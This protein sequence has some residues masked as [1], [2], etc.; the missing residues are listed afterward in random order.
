MPST[1][2]SSATTPSYTG[3]AGTRDTGR[4]T[5]SYTGRTATTDLGRAA[6][7]DLGGSSRYEGRGSLSSGLTRES[8]GG[9]TRGSS[10]GFTR[11]SSGGYTGTTRSS[12][13]TVPSALDDS[14]R[15][16]GSIDL[17]PA[18]SSR[19]TRPT[20]SS[21]PRLYGSGDRTPVSSR[22]LALTERL[23]AAESSAKVRTET[24]PGRELSTGRLVDRYTPSASD[25][26]RTRTRTTGAP[27]AGRPVAGRPGAARRAAA[28]TL[29]S[30]T[31]PERGRP[32]RSTSP[33]AR[34]RLRERKEGGGMT[35]AER[36]DKWKKQQRRYYQKKAETPGFG[37]HMSSVST[38]VAE[39][40]DLALRAALGANP[41]TGPM[42]GYGG[43]H[44]R[45]GD[46]R[47]YRYTRQG[48][49][50][51]YWNNEGWRWWLGWGWGWGYCWDWCW[52]WS[53]SWW[54]RHSC[55]GWSTWYWPTYVYCSPA[56][57]YETIEVPVYI[58]PE[59]KVVVADPAPVQGPAPQDSGMAHRA[60]SEYMA[61][62]DRAFVEGRYGDAVH[63]YA[64][65][66]EFSPEDG[67]LYLVLSD[68]LF[69][70]GD[71]HYC[72]FAIRRALELNP[73]LA[74][75]AVDKRTFYGD[76]TDFDLQLELLEVYL[77]DHFLDGDARLVLAANYLFGDQPQ[78]CVD[79][80]DSPFSE[81][82]RNGETG[83]LL[84]AAAVGKLAGAGK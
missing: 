71:Y 36:Q 39:A 17:S 68:A 66:I 4:T 26:G 77:A 60:A 10:G 59:E 2:G 84:L 50:D 58:E 34:E 29:R 27:A 73:E 82:V 44:G 30:R 32:E 13:S 69:A 49:W 41:I 56:V 78:R 19:P 81:E 25:R 28:E 55:G 53:C 79:L 63:Y 48:C 20:T 61:L 21:V 42:C 23:R 24:A 62:G 43:N 15:R 57:I 70:T 35:P 47:W 5:P 22:R 12:R 72:A 67:V 9:Y 80:F 75:L 64:K 83:S 14:S 37:S 1:G 18:V 7:T 51:W 38:A 40:N 76:P 33:S 45:H 54:H 3:R 16:G 31:T 46:D 11:D 74:S 52:G 8:S 65:A 6:A